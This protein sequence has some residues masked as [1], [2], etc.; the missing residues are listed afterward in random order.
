MVAYDEPRDR[1]G[2]FYTFTAGA[3]T[4]LII[5]N[6]RHSQLDREIESIDCFCA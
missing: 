4:D 6:L 5:N 2:H 3:S 1:R